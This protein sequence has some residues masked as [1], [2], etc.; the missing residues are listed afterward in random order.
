MKIRAL[1]LIFIL[2]FFSCSYI[3]KGTKTAEDQLVIRY[4][5]LN[6]IYNFMVNRD[7]DALK[8][9]REREKIL[10]RLN[11]IKHQ[12][13]IIKSKNDKLL[14]E[15]NQ[16]NKDLKEI[17][18]KGELYKKKILSQ[19]NISVKKVANRIKADYI[20]NI[21]DE[22]IF[23]RKKYDVTEEIIREIIRLEKRTAP[24]SR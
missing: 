23:S 17:E 8:I 18:L 7:R 12:I 9:K 21:G 13:I 11:D 6:S 2:L 20:F 10:E 1:I 19:I 16:K 5:N 14:K 24:V 22:V 3:K 15:Y 4:M